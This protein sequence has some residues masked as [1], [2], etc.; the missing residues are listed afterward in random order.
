VDAA[1]AETNETRPSSAAEVRSSHHLVEENALSVQSSR[2]H[3]AGTTGPPADPV[4]DITTASYFALIPCAYMHT[5][6]YSTQ[7]VSSGK[8]KKNYQF[9]KLKHADT[10][11]SIFPLGFL[12]PACF[13]TEPLEGK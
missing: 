2:H 4:P 7:I 12:P 3:P 10:D 13:G 5:K 6:Y 11:A 1:S 9:P 8:S